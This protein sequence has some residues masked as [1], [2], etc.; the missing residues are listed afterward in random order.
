[1]QYDGSV[2][3]TD[4]SSDALEIR[5]DVP[6][7]SI[8]LVSDG[9]SDGW[10]ATPLDEDDHREYRVLPAD[11]ILRG[12]PLARGHHHLRLEY[13]PRAFVV[14]AWVSVVSLVVYAGLAAVCFYRRPRRAA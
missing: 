14:G 5:A 12:I 6:Q 7:A 9:Y 4:L 11:Y 2:R 8:L 1:V 10:T 13:R 3:V